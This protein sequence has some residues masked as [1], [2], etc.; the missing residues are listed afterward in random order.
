MIR[1][2]YSG[3]FL[4][5]KGTEWRVAILQ[6]ADEAFGMVGDLVFLSGSEVEIEWVHRDKE[7]VVCGS[8][9]TITLLSPGDRTYADLYAIA[10]GSV[11]LDIYRCGEMYW[12]GLLDPELY[13]EP[14]AYGSAYA[15]TLTFSDFGILDRLRY[16][17][18]GIRTVRDVLSDALARSG[19][20]Y[21]TVIDGNVSTMVPGYQDTPALDSL[22]VR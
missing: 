11:R 20:P 13:D 21:S 15:V 9:A 14:Y 7:E 10:P 3:S 6:D 1:E 12:S 17:L 16:N 2:R 4:G 19:L 18:T 8:T 5:V 22:A